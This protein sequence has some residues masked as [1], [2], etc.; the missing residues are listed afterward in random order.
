V[1]DEVPLV[2][3]EAVPI[4]LV[5]RKVDFLSRPERSLRLFLEL[6]Y[7]GVLNR[8]KHEAVGVLSE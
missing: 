1:L 4:L 6:P 7:F 2:V 8:E 3:V 5:L